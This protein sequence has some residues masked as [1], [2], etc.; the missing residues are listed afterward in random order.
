MYDAD[1]ADELQRPCFFTMR[2]GYL[3]FFILPFITFIPENLVFSDSAKISNPVTVSRA[4]GDQSDTG[5]ICQTVAGSIR[6]YSAWITMSAVCRSVI[7]C[8]LQ[9]LHRLP[10]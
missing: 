6:Q 2:G 10:Q 3:P 1:S 5:G 4:A 9:A 7:Q 8:E